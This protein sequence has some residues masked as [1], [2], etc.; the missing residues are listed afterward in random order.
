MAEIK[1]NRWLEKIVANPDLV[2]DEVYDYSV[3]DDN[4]VNQAIKNRSFVGKPLF[5][6]GISVELDGSDILTYDKHGS[7]KYQFLFVPVGF[8]PKEGKEVIQ[9]IILKIT[10][11][12]NDIPIRFLFSSK[13][14][15]LQIDYLDR[16]AFFGDGYKKIFKE[17]EKVMPIN[18]IGAVLN[19]NEYFGL[20]GDK[21]LFSGRNENALV[22]ATHEIGHHLG[23][24]DGYERYYNPDSM[25]GTELFTA[26][27]KLNPQMR[28]AAR[29]YGPPIFKTGNH[30]DGKAIYKFY[31]KSIMGDATW[32]Y[33]DVLENGSDEDKAQI[34]N[35]LQKHVMR[36]YA[37]FKWSKLRGS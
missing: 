20:G 15:P 8:T 30:Y 3:C 28:Y 24:N 23:L 17:L 13:S 35:D 29:K 7:N 10:P 26:I 4:P 31:E 25:N 9:E 19:S 34:F 2:K 18:G 36:Y 6:S 12:F 11:A 21:I 33:Q 14:L 22:L 5:R 16:T 27:S 32:S 37:K 1:K